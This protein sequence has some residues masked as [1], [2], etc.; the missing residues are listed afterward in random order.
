MRLNSRSFESGVAAPKRTAEN[1]ARAADVVTNS[2]Y[3]NAKIQDTSRSDRPCIAESA[4]LSPSIAPTTASHCAFPAAPLTP[5]N[6]I[7]AFGV[8][9]PCRAALFGRNIDSAR[10]RRLI[11]T[12]SFRQNRIKLETEPRASRAV[13]FCPIPPAHRLGAG[14][15]PR[16]CCKLPV[17]CYQVCAAAIVA[18]WRHRTR[19]ESDL[20]T[21]C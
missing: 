3:Q 8:D 18:T 17:S 20:I 12:S 14:P 11:H 6:S 4:F 21:S 13:L 5:R 7:S 2:E 16:H 9:P 10:S 19:L 1:N 15:R